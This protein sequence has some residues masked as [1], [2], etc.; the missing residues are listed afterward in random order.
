MAYASYKYGN[1]FASNVCCSSISYNC[2]LTDGNIFIFNYNGWSR[3]RNYVNM[4]VLP[5]GSTNGKKHGIKQAG[6]G[7]N[8][9]HEVAVV[10]EM[11]RDKVSSEEV[12]SVLKSIAEPNAA[13]SY[14]KSVAQLPNFVH[15][16][17]A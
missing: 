8:C 6:I 2:A 9:S 14:F 1:L 4:K 11:R 13:L 3:R 10:N 12:M 7:T 5:N 16:T 17:E 15:T